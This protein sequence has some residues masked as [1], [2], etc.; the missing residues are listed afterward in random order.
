MTLVVP[1]VGEVIALTKFLD[2]S[3]YIRLYSNDVTPSNTTTTASFVECTGGGYSE[4]LILPGDWV[5][6]Q[7]DPSNAESPELTWTFTGA[8]TPAPG[9]YG[10]YIVDASNVLLWAERF[11]VVPI[12]PVLDSTAKITPRITAN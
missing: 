11:P 12:L 3:L 4:K 6:T 10:Y 5:I 9:L 1:A 7:G 2:S 8:P